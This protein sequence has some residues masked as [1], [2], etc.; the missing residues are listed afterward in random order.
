MS[1]CT[2]LGN[3]TCP[4]IWGCIWRNG[5]GESSHPDDG[6]QIVFQNKTLTVSGRICMDA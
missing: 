5:C 2:A 6:F 1:H 3:T 4:S